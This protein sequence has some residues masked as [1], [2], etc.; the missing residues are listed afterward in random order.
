[1]SS[2]IMAIL[3]QLLW[4]SMPPL[5]SCAVSIASFCASIR[6]EP[7]ARLLLAPLLLGSALI[8]LR[9]SR[10][11]VWLNGAD[12]LWALLMCSWILHSVSALY[13]ESVTPDIVF[14]GSMSHI[15][16]LHAT[17]KLFND[18]RGISRRPAAAEGL[19]RHRS[20]HAPEGKL[21][22]SLK[23]LC[24]AVS[25]LLA[26]GTIIGPFISSRFL[27]EA[28]DFVSYKQMYLR[29]FMLQAF[30]QM[31]ASHCITWR[32]TQLR[33]LMAVNW[34]WTAYVMIEVCHCVL[35]LLFVS[36][37]RLD[38]PEEW[39]PLFGNVY[40][41]SG[42]RRFWTRFWHT[43]HA[44]SCLTIGAAVMENAPG[45]RFLEPNS[46]LY[47]TAMALWVFVLSGLCH[48]LADCVC[49]LPVSTAIASL[50]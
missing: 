22:F 20:R 17:Y 3:P 24:K 39:P 26:N 45:L 11:L 30:G 18:P 15:S 31:S 48:T 40:E 41:A 16:S 43:L 14:D 29:R 10:R 28:S 36:V 9:S 7:R 5:C 6:L 27:F 46:R 50:K 49:G 8:S 1:M 23:R 21:S 32:E 25:L 19:A 4:Y 2:S 44:R 47:K 35:A 42:I 37:V 12:N 38:E 33:A 13:I 34:I